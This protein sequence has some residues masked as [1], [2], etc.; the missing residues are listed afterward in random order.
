MNNPGI[1]LGETFKISSATTPTPP[2]R[3]FHT[4]TGQVKESG[5]THVNYTWL[6]YVTGPLVCTTEK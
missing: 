4:G 1:S 6:E 3:E 5:S 2:A